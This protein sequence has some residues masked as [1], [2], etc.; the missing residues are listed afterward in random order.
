MRPHPL[1]PLARHQ[2]RHHA[3]HQGR[4]P[5]PCFLSLPRSV[6]LY[7]FAL[8]LVR[9]C[10]LPC[11]HMPFFHGLLPI[12]RAFVGGALVPWMLRVSLL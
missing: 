2:G 8:H 12:D 4:L 10:A 1:L 5:G 9:V 3:R 11:A 6:M 7:G